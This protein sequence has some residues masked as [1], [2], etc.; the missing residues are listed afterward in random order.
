MDLH[1]EEDMTFTYPTK[2][3]PTQIPMQTLAALTV[4]RADT[5][6][7][8]PSPEHSWQDRITLH[9]T[10]LKLSMKQRKKR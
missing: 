2:R 8:A 9:L 5:V 6:I 10:K 3:H 1:S 7:R 4:H